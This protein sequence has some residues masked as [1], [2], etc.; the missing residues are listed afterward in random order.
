METQEKRSEK[1]SQSITVKAL[2]VGFLSLLLLIPSAMMQELI[3]ERK[4]RSEETIEKINNK[5]SGAQTLCA[6]VLSIPY[7]VSTLNAEGKMVN[8]Q[9]LLHLT[10]E[11]LHVDVALSPEEKHYGIYKTI[12]YKSEVRLKGGFEIPDIEE[13]GR[14]YHWDKAIVYIGIS[15]LRGVTNRVDF[16]I[17]DR[18]YAAAAGSR[19]AWFAGNEL[20]V[21]L[22]DKANLAANK[23][24]SFHCTIDLNGSG[25]MHFIPIGKTSQ[26]H[27]AGAWKAPGFIG[28]FSPE[29]TITESGFDATWKI[30]HFN[31]SIP[32]SWIDNGVQPF[33][34]S[35]FGVNLV[36]TVDHYQQNMRSAKYAI[37]FIAL[38]FVI[39]FFVELLTKKRIHPIQYLLVGLALV[40]FYALL[41][42]ISE[43]VGFA[44]AYL[45]AS[46][47]TIGM[48]TLYAQSV[49]KNRKQ[50]ALLTSTLC[51]LY[52]FLYVILQLEE[53]ALL[54]GSIGLFLVLA[55]IMYFSRKVNWYKEGTV[56]E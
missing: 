49:F 44:I 40:L 25:S 20:V 5:W 48:I 18:A 21:P 1:F 33:A 6:P 50:T 52:L 43:Q 29:H 27:M 32:D 36:D 38:T 23:A 19:R 13:A 45:I 4:H 22:N 8:E 37:L 12:L 24:I 56:G 34:E 2:I 9:H 47:A 16:Y 51:L 14:T 42:S 26:V 31:R 10:P 30:L 41:L 28:H 54:I 17:N 15:D 11:D 3:S 53:I 35:S 7:T 39:F 46:V 55:V